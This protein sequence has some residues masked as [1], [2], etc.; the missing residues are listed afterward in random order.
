[1]IRS[2]LEIAGI[3]VFAASG[4]LSAGRKGMDLVGVAVIAVVTALGGGTLR[5]LLLERHPV[6]WIANTSYLWACLAASALTLFYVRYRE[7][8][9]RALAIADALGLALFT[10]GGAQIA[11]Q[12]GANGLV[13]VLMG[14]MTGTAG[15]VLRDV[16]SAEVPLIFRSGHL[17]ASA[18]LAGTVL[19]QVLDQLG[20]PRDVSGL[21]GMA[22]IAGLRIGAIIFDWRLPTPRVR[23]RHESQEGPRPG[24]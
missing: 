3:M 9:A 22:L 14:V 19:Y 17:Y 24:V 23:D 2:L 1:M 20:V 8:P 16:L 4:V 6:S 7:P 12:A 5:D 11:Q 18:A 10:I 15:G 13:M 21:A